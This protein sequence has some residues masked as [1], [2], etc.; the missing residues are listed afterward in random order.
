MPAALSRPAVAGPLVLVAMLVAVALTRLL[1]HPPN[2]TP[3]AALALFGA[4]HFAHRGW[5]VAVPLLA[6]FLSDIALGFASG[7]LG[8][9]W[10][11]DTALYAEYMLSPLALGIYASTLLA[12]LPGFALRG[13]ASA[14]RVLGAGV[15][16]ALVF[17]FASNAVA[18]LGAR[19]GEPCVAG[20]GPCYVA[21][22]P[23]LKWTLAGTLFYS[24]LLFG[25]FA[26]LRR[27]L[28]PLR[29]QTA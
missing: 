23:F 10:T 12:G 7:A 17:F 27:A 14:R 25:G 16:S 15:A 18:W 1:P 9:G 5:A 22:L 28:P 3:V 26:L 19:P 13:R 6:L 21:A 11:A 4:A 24:A 2:F 8:L 20:I 29:P